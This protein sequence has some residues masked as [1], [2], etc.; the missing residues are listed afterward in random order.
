MFIF[1]Q[2]K[3][4]IYLNKVGVE[5]TGLLMFRVINIIYATL[6][7]GNFNAVLQHSQFSFCMHFILFSGMVWK[8]IF[9]QLK[10]MS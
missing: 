6:R 8:L 4:M 10:L 9:L 1:V 3:L 7:T 5:E 2:R